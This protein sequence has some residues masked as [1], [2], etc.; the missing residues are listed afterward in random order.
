MLQKFAYTPSK[1]T[2]TVGDPEID[3]ML[4]AILRE[5]DRGKIDALM[6]SVFARLRSEHVGVPLV[7]LDTPYATSKRV[8]RW[9]PGS[10]MLDLNLDELAAER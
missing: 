5:T 8:A 7:Y 2:D 10:V 9:N 4:S 3:A 6:R 1:P